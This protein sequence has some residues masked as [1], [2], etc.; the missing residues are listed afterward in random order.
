[1]N[2][3]IIAGI[4]LVAIFILFLTEKLP[5]ATTALIGAIAVGCFGL[6]E[7][8]TVFQSFTSNSVIL[9][10]SMM[11]VG[12]S[13]FYSGLGNIIGKKLLKFTGSNERSIIFVGALAGALLSSVCSGTAT[14]VT[15]FPIVTSM[16]IAA[17]ISVSRVYLPYIYGVGFGS[18]LTLVG[19]GLGP[20]SSAILEEAGY[21]G[22]SF[23][24]PA[25]VGVPLMLVGMIVLLTVG[26]KLLPTHHIDGENVDKDNTPV[27][28]TKD[29]W[30]SA[31]V[32]LT[33]VVFMMLEPEGI[34]LYIISSIGAVVLVITGCM[35]QKQFYGSISWNSVFLIAGMSTV[36]KGIQTSGLAEIIANSMIKLVGGTTNELIVIGM[37]LLV[38]SILT[39][40]LSNNAA[41][42]LMAPIALG[43]AET[44]GIDP[45]TL[46]MT[47]YVGALSSFCTPM[48]T[49][50]IS[51]I[52]EPGGYKIKDLFRIGIVMQV[53]YFVVGM[54][55]IPM[56]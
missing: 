52:M 8:D 27:K 7:F 48:A 38:T 55:V 15:L 28:M 50:A 11:V 34:P 31:I 39:N 20:A 4:I 35:S 42:L 26:V 17:G 30:I 32:L 18:M 29:M 45:R 49:P 40:F 21:K 10:I 47:V 25:K 3:A 22:W 53:A 12:S 33:V 44:I 56:I 36:A 14:M 24:E 5:L 37:L 46:I 41:L 51:Y 54:I 43:M 9:M 19:S 2:Q 6:V 13:L 23:L 16:C 1:M